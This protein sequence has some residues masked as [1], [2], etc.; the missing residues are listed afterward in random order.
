[1]AISHVCSIDG[2]GKEHVARGWCNVHYRRW[3]AHGDP[4]GGATSPNEAQRYFQATVLRYEGDECL[5][6]PFA[7]NAAGYGLMRHEG[8]SK[9]VSRVICRDVNGPPPTPEHEAAHSCGRGE[10]GCVT[11]RHLFWKTHTENMADKN[12]HGTVARGHR[13]GMAKLT[14]ERVRQIRALKG[15]IP[16]RE[17]GE[18]F[19]IAQQQ[20]SDILSG[21]NWGWLA[22]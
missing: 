6:W 7:R 21:K 1:M 20:V 12:S 11:K 10:D 19:S 13:H 8:G 22:D 18:R 14:E 15:T 17:I 9:L 4:L 2:C 3:K 5:I 16:Q